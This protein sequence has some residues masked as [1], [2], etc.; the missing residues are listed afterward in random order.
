MSAAARQG[1]GTPVRV[2]NVRSWLFVPADHERR[3][4]SALGCGA[5][6]VILDLE[7]AVAISEKPRARE[8]ALAWVR[9]PREP[10]LYVR[11][12]GLDEGCFQDLDAIVAKGLDGILLPKTEQA[13]QLEQVVAQIRALEKARGLT[14]GSIDLIA[15]IE[16][17]KGVANLGE[18]AAAVPPRGRLALGAGDFTLDMGIE[19]T[20]EEEELEQV[21]F[22]VALWS[23]VHRLAPP[24]DSV[25]LGL[26]DPE[27]LKASV[28][29]GARWGFG[30]KAC[31]HPDQIPVVHDG[32]TPPD[33]LLA[34][35]LEIVRS[36]QEAEAR[37]V[38]AIQVNGKLVDYPIAQKAKNLL[39]RH[40]QALP[41]N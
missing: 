3:V 14:T 33:E 19:W 26:K 11:V 35:A 37:G 34:E 38:A 17:C 12:N 29:R 6:A 15:I 31:I 5:D 32:L 10:R 18:I 28:A 36:F 9:E 20:R 16:T 8:M 30:S 25:F 13:G 27:G 7:D 41:I 40:G 21:R 23:R 1:E 24:M 4:R 22:L 2:K 39:E